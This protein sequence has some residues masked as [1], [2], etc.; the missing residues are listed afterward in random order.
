MSDE[1]VFKVGRMT[2]D[3]WSMI[4][5]ERIEWQKETARRT[6]DYLFSIG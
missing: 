3:P 6:R 2:R 4:R 5:E 1:V